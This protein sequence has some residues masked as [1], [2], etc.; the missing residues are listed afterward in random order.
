MLAAGHLCIRSLSVRR[1]SGTS[2]SGVAVGVFKAGGGRWAVALG[3]VGRSVQIAVG[4]LIRELHHLRERVHA[5]CR[6]P[7]ASAA[8]VDA[9][10]GA[11]EREERGN[12]RWPAGPPRPARPNAHRPRPQGD[13]SRPD[14]L[15]NCK[16]SQPMS[17]SNENPSKKKTRYENKNKNP[18]ASCLQFVGV[19]KIPASYDVR[20]QISEAGRPDGQNPAERRDRSLVGPVLAVRPTATT[21][22]SSGGAACTYWMEISRRRSPPGPR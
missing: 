4:E 11:G 22:C 2:S 1:S 20:A 19:T 13:G 12:G 8:M 10:G 18:Y 15:K 14:Q 9:C 16:L 7:L 5:R 3:S 21:S 17:P 6:L